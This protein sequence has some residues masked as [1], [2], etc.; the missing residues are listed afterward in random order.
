MEQSDDVRPL[1]PIPKRQPRLGHS[2]RNH[3]HNRRRAVS[4]GGF[5]GTPFENLSLSADEKKQEEANGYS[6][7]PLIKESNRIKIPGVPPKRGHRRGGSWDLL[8]KVPRDIHSIKV[9]RPLPR[10]YSDLERDQ[11][12]QGWKRNQLTAMALAMGGPGFPSCSIRE[13][14]ASDCIEKF[15][16]LLLDYLSMGG[17]VDDTATFK[18]FFGHHMGL[19]GWTLL[20]VA[21]CAYINAPQCMLLLLNHGANPLLRDSTGRTVLAEAMATAR[22][23]ATGPIDILQSRVSDSEQ[24]ASRLCDVTEAMMYKL[25]RGK[26]GITPQQTRQEFV[27]MRFHGFT[28]YE[29]VYRPEDIDNHF[30]YMHL[31]NL[32]ELQSRSS[33]PHTGDSSCLSLLP[34]VI[35]DPT[36]ATNSRIIFVS[37]RWLGGNHPDNDQNEKFHAIVQLG[38]AYCEIHETDP[39]DCF[40]WVDYCCIQQTDTRL[41][42]LGIQALPFYILL[43]DAFIAIE[44]DTYM[45]RAWCLL[46]YLLGCFMP[47]K[48]MGYDLY[49]FDSSTGALNE[50]APSQSDLCLLQPQKAGV[51]DPS[52]MEYIRALTWFAETHLYKWL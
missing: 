28:C 42:T 47:A 10:T 29:K 33:L 39:E 9:V 17:N 34:Q 7:H 2:Y 13:G 24:S 38:L 43:A 4:Y 32:K 6:D 40:L 3:Q 22:H 36:L 5:E 27:Q 12:E 44:N 31:L 41:K 51:T 21:A 15:E 35:S 19:K 16:P 46:E 11:D 8:S 49:K 37:H 26:M 25:R 30:A 52:D 18:D 48:T 1:S 14:Q 23:G 50:I 20:R 45:T